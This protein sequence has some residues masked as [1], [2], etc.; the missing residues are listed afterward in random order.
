MPRIILIGY[1]ESQKVVPLSKYLLKKY[2]PD[3]NVLWLNYHGE[4]DGWSKFLRQYLSNLP[5][6][7]IIF[8]LD[9]YLVTGFDEEAYKEA[10]STWPCVKLCYATEK[11]HV[12]YPVTTQYTIWDKKE[13]IN[14]LKQTNSPWN[15]EMTGSALFKGVSNLKPCVK[16]YTNSS[17]SSRWKGVDLQG[18]SDEDKEMAKKLL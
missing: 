10:E 3:F 9:D 2:M 11:E 6:K 4:V 1:P 15:F 18:L 5:D 12:E 13:L 14:L 8:G 16:Y 7:K 17:I